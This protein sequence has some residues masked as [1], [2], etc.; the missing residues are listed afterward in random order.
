MRAGWNATIEERT[1]RPDA[2]TRPFPVFTVIEKNA[3]GT[4][5][6][7]MRQT[8]DDWGQADGTAPGPPPT[9]ADFDFLPEGDVRLKD[10]IVTLLE[11]TAHNAYFTDLDSN[12]PFFCARI[13]WGGTE[14]TEFEI[15]QLLVWLNP[16]TGAGTRQ[17]VTWRLE[18]YQLM[19]TGFLT[20]VSRQLVL[21]KLADPLDVA[22]AGDSEGLVTFDYTVAP[23]IQRPQPKKITP[24]VR[25]LLALN[26]IFANAGPVPIT[27]VIIKALKA[28]GSAAGNVGWGYNS[29]AAS[30]S[31]GSNVLSSRKLKAPSGISLGTFL[32][33]VF[34]DPTHLD[35][36]SAGGTPRMTIKSGTYATVEKTLSFTTNLFDLGGAPSGDVVLT[37]QGNVPN[38]CTL[39]GRIRNNADS[40]WVNFTSG[41]R[42]IADLGLTPTTTRKMQA[43]LTANAAGTQTP[44]LTRLGL[45]AVLE[46]NLIRQSRIT[47]G[48][49]AIDPLT[50]KGEIPEIEISLIR[51]GIRD[52]ASAIED[53]MSGNYIGD[54][55]ISIYYGDEML[56]NQSRSLCLHVDDFL[57]DGVSNRGAE[58]VLRCLSINCLLRDMVPRYE[59]GEILAPDGD[60]AVGAWTTDAGGGANLYQRIDEAVFDDADYIRSDLTPSNSGCSVTLPTPS[61]PVGR[62]HI[63]DYRYRKDATGGE[64]IDLTVSLYCGATLL[65]ETTHTNITTDAAGFSTL[66]SFSLTDDQVKLITDYTQLLVKFTANKFSGAGARRA[67]VTWCRFRTGGKRDQVTFLNQTL[68]SVWQSLM[69]NE[70]GMDARYV[71]PGPEDT[72]TTVSKMI[73]EAQQQGKPV[74]KAEVDAI[75]QL[76]GGGNLPSQGR[77]KFVDMYGPK[78]IR[79]IFP[80]SE[81]VLPDA[82][83][84]Y[85][86]RVPEYFV[87]FNWN[88]IKGDFDDEVRVF[89]SGA[90]T[91]LGKARLDPLR[92]LDDEVSK[93]IATEALARAVGERHVK[94]V[95]PGLMEWPFNA[96]YAHP[97]LEPGDVVLL[98]TDKFVSRDPNAANAIRG[99]SWVLACISSCDVTAKR[100]KGWVR[101]HSDILPSNEGSDRLG[102]GPATP[103]IMALKVTIDESG[104]SHAV[105]ATNAATAVRFAASTAGMP[106]DATARAAAL[107]TVDASGYFYTGNILTG[108]TPGQTVFVKAFGYEKVDGSGLESPAASA[109][110]KMGTR[111]RAFILDDG[112]YILR[113]ANPSGVL[114]DS[115]VQL[116]PAN[117]IKEG[118][119]VQLLYRH[120]EEL[121]V[122]GPDADGDVD[123]TFSQVYQNAPMVIFKGGQY[124][125]F[126]NTLPAGKQR[127]RLQAI[128]V[129]TT[130][131]RSRAIIVNT[132]ATTAQDDDFASGNELTAAGQT[133]EVTLVP[134]AA[135]GDTFNVHYFVSVTL[136]SPG[137]D[138]NVTLTVAID[139]DDGGGFIERATFIYSR[140]TA[141]TSTFNEEIKAIVVS[142]L[143]SGKKIRLRAKGF[144]VHDAVGSFKIRGGD[145]GGS[146]P[147]TYHGVTYTTAT[148]TPESAIPADGDQVVWVAQEVT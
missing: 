79:A 22:V 18:L 53:L 109:T 46:Y 146:N 86:Q 81:L 88:S 131:F 137:A 2:T 45:G 54:Q 113:A 26:D 38:G 28:D 27:F 50:M 105:I 13:E 141:G 23:V 121:I 52:Y 83:P 17:V 102:L 124:I 130:G 125:S 92:T 140:S 122:N 66:G 49:W 61:D 68:K 39:Q 104:D 138:P 32:N 70:L 147:E 51:D 21:A 132:G 64:N 55:L 96:K 5:R 7:K 40:A 56:W 29:A 100:F 25:D 148:E 94:A 120:R 15:D 84:G 33:G 129:T 77:I 4:L 85:E 20:G 19:Q 93:W 91:N 59:P 143:T 80:S 97:F 115:T 48:D 30:V 9:H 47:G 10:T 6:Q 57:I 60:N 98:Q 142:G 78:P 1:L 65:A 90:L 111:K 103:H 123:V 34:D 116:D 36:G 127:L 37:I 128:N 72:T 35:D 134:G 110:V 76:A 126:S 135:L 108:V 14:P 41:Q 62:R 87:R 63:V 95:G 99:Q 118:G 119:V 71:G 58:I 107:Q 114:A 11:N 67:V 43:G 145:A 73:L 101:N 16:R 89:H 133:A 8:R 12:F 31:T 112:L 139:T 117:G 75:A 24:L 69:V 106:S 3:N 136:S 74:S 82:T 42:M 144:V 44:T